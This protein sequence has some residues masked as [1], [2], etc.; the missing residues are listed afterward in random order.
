MISSI[1]DSQSL[2]R[3]EN[4]GGERSRG[5][6][7]VV[8]AQVCEH[9]PHVFVCSGRVIDC[10]SIFLFIVTPFLLYSWWFFQMDI[11]SVAFLYV[12]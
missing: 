2:L 7:L 10:T 8:F 1:E 9:K 3:V 5:D 12:L 4:G 11:D 6:T